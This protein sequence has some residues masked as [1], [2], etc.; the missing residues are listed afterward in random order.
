[1]STSGNAALADP[2]CVADDEREAERFGQDDLADP[3]IEAQDVDVDDSQE[4]RDAKQGQWRYH[5]PACGQLL[6]VP[7]PSVRCGSGTHSTYPSC[8]RHAA[9]NAE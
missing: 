2:P 8:H 4:Q 6:L 9:S 1:M 3:L 7:A 5:G